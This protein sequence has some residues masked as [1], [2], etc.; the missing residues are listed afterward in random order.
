LGCASG[1][2]GELETIDVKTRDRKAR[3]FSDS[4]R[5]KARTHMEGYFSQ[6][7]LGSKRGG[8]VLQP[9]S[10]TSH[11]KTG[12]REGNKGV[13]VPTIKRQAEKDRNPFTVGRQVG[14]RGGTECAGKESLVGEEGG[15]WLEGDQPAKKK[16]AKKNLKGGPQTHATTS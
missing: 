9:A 3:G 12:K 5:K 16:R 8:G 6:K 14:I 1:K 2:M 11:K 15:G 4:M 13:K 10:Q 7:T